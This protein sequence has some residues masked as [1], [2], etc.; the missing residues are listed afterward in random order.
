MTLVK[1]KPALSNFDSLLDSFFPVTYGAPRLETP[2]TNVLET[3]DSY[4]IEMNVPGRNKEDFNLLVE[5]DLLTISFEK[6]EEKVE[7]DRKFIRREFNFQNFKRSFS[8]DD[9]IDASKI[10]A[11]YENGILKIDLPKKEDKKELTRQI[12]IS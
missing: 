5:N 3:K 10:E 11:R 4:V 2:S 6:K 1:F 12:S 9:S 8:L 7:E